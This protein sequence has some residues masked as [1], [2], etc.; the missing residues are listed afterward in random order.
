MPIIEGLKTFAGELDKEA[1]KPITAFSG[2]R[3]EQ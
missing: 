1:E 2:K 3:T